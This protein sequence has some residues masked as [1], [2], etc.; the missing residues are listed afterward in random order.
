MSLEVHKITEQLPAAAQLW[1]VLAGAVFLSLLLSW[2]AGKI[3]PLKL[4]NSSRDIFCS[5][6]ASCW[7]NSDVLSGQRWQRGSPF[8]LWGCRP[9]LKMY[10]GCA[11]KGFDILY[12]LYEIQTSGLAIHSLDLTLES[13]RK[14]KRSLQ[15]I[16]WIEALQ[17]NQHNLKSNMANV[18]M[19]CRACYF[20]LKGIQHITTLKTLKGCLFI[21]HLPLSVAI[22]FE[23]NHDMQKH[24]I[25]AFSSNV[26]AEQ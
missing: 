16:P 24:F 17:S 21:L 22:K 26:E 23:I 8:I 18:S 25:T 9:S 12:V 6:W 5:A 3:K 20:K 4:E 10:S 7:S 1:I 13:Q 2:L 14:P 11:Q 15:I 19:V